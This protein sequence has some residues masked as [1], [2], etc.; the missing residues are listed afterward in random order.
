MDIWP[1][2]AWLT[3]T[4]LLKSSGTR[5]R[6]NCRYWTEAFKTGFLR[7]KSPAVNH[8]LSLFPALLLIH[9]LGG[10]IQR[11][12]GGQ[13]LEIQ[14]VRPEDSGHYS[15]VVTNIAGSNSLFFTVEIICKSDC[16]K[17]WYFSKILNSFTNNNLSL[18]LS[19]ATSDKRGQR[20]GNGSDQP[21]SSFT[22]WIWRRYIGY[23]YL[24]KRWLPSYSGHQK[25]GSN[26]SPCL[27]T[28]ISKTQALAFSFIHPLPLY[29]FQVH[30]VIRG[31]LACT[32]GSA[33]WCRSLLLHCVQPGRLRPSWS[34]STSVWWLPVTFF[35]FFIYHRLFMTLCCTSMLIALL[36]RLVWF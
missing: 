21:G 36:M 31:V 9:Q 23:C 22:L 11:L 25:V 32:Q 19:S 10:R 27:L 4:Q 28:V 13:Y 34:G 33:E 3:V 7:K 16:L 20:C 5:M 18:W 30:Y 2:S 14:E 35:P 26:I 1:W 29:L 12:A 8:T 6:P 24:E 15:C 17:W